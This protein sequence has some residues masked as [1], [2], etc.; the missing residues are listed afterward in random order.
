MKGSIIKAKKADFDD[1]V[2]KA[3]NEEYS[4]EDIAA[5]NHSLPPYYS[6][7]IPGGVMP[8]E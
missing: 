3:I 1:K 6:K 2:E 4:D 7:G 5:G 8:L